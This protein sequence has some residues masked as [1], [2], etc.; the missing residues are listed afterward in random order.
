[1]YG[2]RSLCPYLNLSKLDKLRRALW[3]LLVALEL[4]AADARHGCLRRRAHILVDEPGLRN[5]RRLHRLLGG[6]VVGAPLL[7][8]ILIDT[9]S[10]TPCEAAPTCE[11]TT[12]GNDGRCQMIESSP[13]CH[14]TSEWTGARCLQPVLEQPSPPTPQ[15]PP[16][17]PPSFPAPLPPPFSSATVLTRTHVLFGL[18]RVS[19]L[20]RD[21]PQVTM[22]LPSRSRSPAPLGAFQTPK[23]VQHCAVGAKPPPPP[24]QTAR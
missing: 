13:Y 21:C 12:C 16:P 6:L 1:M 17:T 5:R 23:S 2:V 22:S 15:P 10:T 7:A 4:A 19:R 14:C 20:I 3:R 8:I 18:S 24:P 9:S 11:T